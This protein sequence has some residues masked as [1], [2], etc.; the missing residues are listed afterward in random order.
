M[1]VPAKLVLFADDTIVAITSDKQELTDGIV[2]DVFQKITKW[3]STNGLSFNF[4]KTQYM[5]GF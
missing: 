5:D 3:F 1:Y 2:N 4:D